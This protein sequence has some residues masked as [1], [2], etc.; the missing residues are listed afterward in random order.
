MTSTVPATLVAMRPHHQLQDRLAALMGITREGRARRLEELLRPRRGDTAGYWLQLSISVLIATLGLAQGS[1]AV[2]IGAMLIA[3]LM[4]PIV[5]LGLGLALGSPLLTFRAAARFVG[6]LLLTLV[7]SAAITRA[8]PFHEL[9]P[10]LLARTSPTMLD[11][12]VA[13]ACALA[14]VYTTVH[15]SGETASA[16]AG[17]AIGISLVP[18]L[19]TAGWGLGVGNGDVAQGAALLFTANFT[20]IVGLTAISVLGLGFGQIDVASLEAG[21]LASESPERTARRIARASGRLFGR[22][23]AVFLR[24]LLPVALLAAIYL[25]LRAA[26][27]EVAW[28]ASAR[29][30]VR[31]ALEPYAHRIVRQS[32]E[33]RRG[34]IRITLIAI[35]DR[36]TNEDALT[37]L[38]A[39]IKRRTGTVPRIDAVYVPDADALAA[40]AATTTT[41]P[42]PIE[43]PPPPPAPAGLRFSAALQ[44]LI[45]ARWPT[46]GGELLATRVEVG[47]TTT[48]ELVHL[49]AELGPAALALLAPELTEALGLPIVVTE[50][51]LPVEVRS[52]PTSAPAMLG[53]WLAMAI[54]A[55][56]LARP[57][58]VTACLEAPAAPVGRRPPPDPSRD[59]AIAALSRRVVADR[60]ELAYTDRWALRFARGPCADVAPPPP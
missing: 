8:L 22:R 25:P 16:A 7:A 51:A 27:S 49:G 26:L 53:A 56:E 34:Q 9:T 44:E 29:T 14:A 32:L 60:H 38:R 41:A 1:T 20:A 59:L 50:R 47:P 36:E 40:L 45:T 5:E 24:V 11:L 6:S 46:P 21:E 37:T 2:V 33:I 35:G 30:D 13:A 10:E 19:C 31:E 23:I 28:Q 43:L 18:P 39:E 17:T 54:D 3:P 15:Q 4:Q 57:F 58:E 48:V 55:I 12:F 52:V 42:P